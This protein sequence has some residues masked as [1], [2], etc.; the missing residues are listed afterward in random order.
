MVSLELAKQH[1]R[2]LH[3]SEDV[4]IQQYIAAAVAWVENY[5]GKLLDRRIVTQVEASLSVGLKLFYG[6]DPETLTVSYTDAEGTPATL[7]DAQIVRS[8]VYPANTWPDT[9]DNT[10]VT[11]NYT[12]GFTE[13]PADLDSAVLLLVGQAYDN[14]EAGAVDASVESLCRPYRSVGV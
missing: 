6:P 1:L 2:V 7:S 14:R 3:S 12:A 9:Q 11:L 10:P 5:T 8:C 13:T 4:L